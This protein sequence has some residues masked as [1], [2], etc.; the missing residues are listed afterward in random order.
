MTTEKKYNQIKM[1]LIGL[2]VLNVL[3]GIYIAFFKKDAYRLETLKVGGDENMNLAVQLYNADAYK[4][5][6][7]S[8]LEQI[9]GSM[10]KTDTTTTQPTAQ[11][12]TTADTTVTPI[13]GDATK[14]A[15]IEKD[16]YIKG[17]K[18]ARITLIEYSDLVCP[19]CKRH[20]EAQTLEKLVAKYPNDV[21]M[22]FRNMP[23]PQLHPSAP[24]GAQGAVC[25]GKLGGESKYY[26]YIDKAFKIEEFTEANVT[27]I[28]V[29]LGLNKSKFA[30]CLTSAETLAT[31]AAQV[32]EG[33]GFGVNGTPGNLVVDNQ[34]GTFTLIAGAYPI[35]TFEAEI[36][37]ILGK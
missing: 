34:K 14:F 25:A 4:Q 32:Q 22:E 16:G 13:Q 12:P 9:L 18:N 5:Q 27:D 23:L 35:E 3:L 7:K 31:V 28:A 1:F 29:G 17:N 33:Q 21:N 24:I 2:L 11:A 37:K 15:A 6:Q 26:A 10:G 20:Y 36:A 19:F 30:T 8:T